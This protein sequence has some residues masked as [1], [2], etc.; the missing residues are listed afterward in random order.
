MRMLFFKRSDGSMGAIPED[1][2]N[3]LEEALRI[4]PMPDPIPEVSML[5]RNIDL[6]ERG[7]QSMRVSATTLEA[8][9]AERQTKLRECRLS[10]E[11]FELAH[12]KM[13]EGQS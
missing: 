7:L 1:I 8:E 2:H 5:A 9:I 10:I 11:A 12:G 6:M 4:Q 3:T 13:V